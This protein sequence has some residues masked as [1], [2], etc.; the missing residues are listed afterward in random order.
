MCSDAAGTVV[1]ILSDEATGTV[2]PVHL[3]VVQTGT[4]AACAAGHPTAAGTVQRHGVAHALGTTTASAPAV[5]GPTG[6]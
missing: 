6:A 4:A 3:E 2:A 5:G 1:H